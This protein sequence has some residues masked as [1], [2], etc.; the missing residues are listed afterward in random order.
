MPKVAKPYKEGNGWCLRRRIKGE[1]F[2]VSGEVTAKAAKDEMD[3]LVR[4]AGGRHK[5]FG[6]GPAQTTL[7]QGL[8]DYGLQT[9]PFLKGA[10][11]ECN[12]INVYL[13]A[14]DMP[15]LQVAKLNADEST[16][17]AAR[18]K[19]AG[20]LLGIR[21]QNKTHQVYFRVTVDGAKPGGERRIAPGLGAH[22]QAQAEQSADSDRQRSRLARSDVDSLTRYQLQAL[23]DAMR[24]EDKSPSTIQ[25]ERA[26]L[27]SF[28]NHSFAIWHWASLSDNVAT[29][30]RMPAPKPF[31]ARVMSA[32]EQERLEQALAECRNDIVEPTLILLLETAMRT[33]EPIT[34]ARWR[35]VDWKGQV[36]RL[37]DSKTN[38]RDVPLS[39]KATVAL[40]RLQELTGGVADEPVVAITYEALK[41]A[42]T[43]A[44]K[45]AGIDQLR[46]Y[47][48]RHTAATRTALQFGNVFLVQ[49]LTGHKTLAMV[50]RYT[51]IGA[52]DLLKAWRAADAAREAAV[53]AQ[54]QAQVA[55]QEQPDAPA[56]SAAADLSTSV[57]QVDFKNRRVA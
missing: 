6:L 22:R 24:K 9:L 2:F 26:L 50:E 35:D 40:T 17:E 29:R 45:R 53:T 36:L 21:R 5:P 1:E 7:A 48:L 44:C 23:V 34:Y 54:P 13:R 12:R 46:L 27:R 33:S 43:R 8:Q 18:L 15:I 16:A 19:D 41:A 28:L 31:K 42:W 39:D 57:V 11:Q 30:L 3:R 10:P 38:A 4:A 37:T 52:A 47:D 20:T 25:N 55:V 32:E 56:A 14:A 49:A 51:H